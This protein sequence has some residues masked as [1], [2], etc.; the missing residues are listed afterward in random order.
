MSGLAIAHGRLVTMA[1]R[2]GKQITIALDARTGKPLWQSAVAPEFRNS[3]GNGPRA[4]PA[5]AGQTVFV[6]T[7]EGVLA[8]LNLED[9]KVSWSH[10][11]VEDLGGEPAEYGMACSPL[12]AGDRVVVTAGA[13]GAA[14]V[15]YEA[16]SGKLA[17]KAGNAPAGYSSPALLEV[18]GAKQI[19]AFT[20]DSLLGLAPDSGAV[21]WRYPYV[22]DFDCNIATP[23][24]IRGQVFISSGENHGSVLLRLKPRGVKF[25]VEEVWASQGPGSVLR[26]EWQTSILLNG[27]LYG[28]D[29]VGGAGPITH[30]TCI[31]AD[32]GERSLAERALR[33]GQPDRGGRQAFHREHER[34]VSRRAGH[35]ERVRGDGP[36][37]RP[38]ANPAGPRSGRRPALPAP[39]QGDRLPRRSQEVDFARATVNRASAS[40]RLR[41]R[42]SFSLG[43]VGPKGRGRGHLAPPSPRTACRSYAHSP[44]GTPAAPRPRPPKK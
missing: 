28:M 39:R 12:V 41:A 36:R 11:V 27:Y 13:P 26:N 23:L 4:A 2:D 25:D 40:G 16:K 42:F 30:L 34:R 6:F 15:A 9:G 8:A 17:W 7:G 33:Q 10:N 37:N 18:G 3:K 21:L 22:T 31:K 19:V 1:Q 44:G 24:A 5:V 35:V 32:T 29:N 20:G 38:R 43:L 14:V